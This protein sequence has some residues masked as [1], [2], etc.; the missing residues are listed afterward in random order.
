[1][2]EIKLEQA[3][4]VFSQEG[5]CVDPEDIEELEIRCESSLGIDNDK[6]C[7]YVLKTEQWSIESSDD[8]KKLFDRIS[9]VIN[10]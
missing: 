3:K 2:N 6:D 9:K 5:N 4:F 8:L 7:F 1:M 10:K